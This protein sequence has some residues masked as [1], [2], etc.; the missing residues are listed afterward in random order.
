MVMAGCST[1]EGVGSDTSTTTVTTAE[2]APQSAITTPPWLAEVQAS[3]AP[4]GLGEGWAPVVG[5]RTLLAGFGE[6][7]AT[8]TASDGTVCDVCL[9]AA[10]TPEQH[11][12]GLM[13]VTDPALGGY[14]GMLFAFD[15]DSGGG[16]WMRNTRL[17]LSIA[18]FDADGVLVSHADMQPCADSAPDCPGYPADGSFRYA[19]EVPLGRLDE[20][21]VVGVDGGP[22]GPRDAVLRLTGAP[23]PEIEPAEG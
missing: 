19:I 10:I 15:S 12:R 16:F 21:G 9:L 11:A 22:A 20:V 8:I 2:P 6:V 23:C 17:A 4:A 13:F 18:Y 14:D 5:G 1:S 7:A 3:P